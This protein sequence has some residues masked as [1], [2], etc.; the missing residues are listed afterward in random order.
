[1]SHA[2]V[3]LVESFAFFSYTDFGFSLGCSFGDEPAPG[4]FRR[5]SFAKALSV[6]AYAKQRPLALRLFATL[7]LVPPLSATMPEI[8]MVRSPPDASLA[9]RWVCGSL[10]L[11]I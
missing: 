7:L 1:M 11:A 5:Q 8:T 6:F 2:A 4:F 10:R 9:L 3:T